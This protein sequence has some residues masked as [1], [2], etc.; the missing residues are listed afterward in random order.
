M[1]T[2][3]RLRTG[4]ALMLPALTALI[5]INLGAPAHAATVAHLSSCSLDSIRGGVDWVAVLPG[6]PRRPG[7]L[8]GLGRR[9]LARRVH[10]PLAGV[11]VTMSSWGCQ[12]G[13]WGGRSVTT[14]V[15]TSL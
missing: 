15:L 6:E 9:P 11:T 1:L 7:I 12:S 4:M 14:K 3:V 2:N 5:V 8:R 10:L 13:S